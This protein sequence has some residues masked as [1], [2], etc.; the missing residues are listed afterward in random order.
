MDAGSF[1]QYI[2]NEFKAIVTNNVGFLKDYKCK[3]YLK[4]AKSFRQKPFPVV[5]E[6]R[7]IFHYIISEMLEQGIME[8]VDHSDYDLSFSCS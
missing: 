6:K 7:K 3:V 8:E 2:R 1:V 5:K 4:N